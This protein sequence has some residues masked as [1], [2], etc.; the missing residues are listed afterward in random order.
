[1]INQGLFYLDWL[2]DHRGEFELLIMK[3]SGLT[4]IFH[5]R[6]LLA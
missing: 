6:D 1:V 2:L 4:S 5:M 3:S